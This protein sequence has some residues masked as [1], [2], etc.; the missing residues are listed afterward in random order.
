[1]LPARQMGIST[2][3]PSYINAANTAGMIA[4]SFTFMTA[5]TVA[6]GLRLAARFG[7]KKAVWG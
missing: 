4:T 7:N 1:M 3:P 6:Y 5:T 2:P